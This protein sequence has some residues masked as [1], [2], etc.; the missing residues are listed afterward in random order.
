MSVSLSDSVIG[1]VLLAQYNLTAPPP[2]SSS[3]SSSLL[4]L[5]SSSKVFFFESEMVENGGPFT[6]QYRI[7]AYSLEPKHASSPLAHWR[8]YGKKELNT[9]THG[10]TSDSFWLVHI[11]SLQSLINNANLDWLRICCS[12]FLVCQY[13][14]DVGVTT[15]SQETECVGGGDT[16]TLLS[17]ARIGIQCAIHTHTHTD[18]ND[19][20]VAQCAN[21]VYYHRISSTFQATLHGVSSFRSSLLFCCFFLSSCLREW[22]MTRME[23]HFI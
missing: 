8:F 11:L 23:T 14:K 10:L 7:V 20:S 1:V 18:V 19:C 4:V 21:R 6:R 16:T 9:Q 15:M 17:N 12:L 13:G 3:S 22:H 2:P 5:S